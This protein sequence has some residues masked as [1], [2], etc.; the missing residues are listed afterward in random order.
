M[1][2]DAKDPEKSTEHLTLLMPP[3]SRCEGDSDEV[4]SKKVD[5]LM[6]FVCMVNDED[7]DICEEVQEGVPKRGISRW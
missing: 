5:G 2:P 6:D 3:G 1:L 7:V 4:Y